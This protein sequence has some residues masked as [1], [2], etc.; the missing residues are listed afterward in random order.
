MKNLNL[1]NLMI[2]SLLTFSAKVEVV[3]K[4]EVNQVTRIK[5]IKN[6]NPA[7]FSNQRSA[8]GKKQCS[9]YT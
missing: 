3:Q 2:L 5:C 9:V 1:I 4:S 8:F 7:N 6:T